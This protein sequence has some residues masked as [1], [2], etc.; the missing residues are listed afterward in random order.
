MIFDP[1][2]VLVLGAGASAP[3]GFPLGHQ[4]K[5]Q[6]IDTTAGD[7]TVS[8]RR[9]QFKEAGFDEKE[10]RE[11]HA[12][13]LR[14]IHPTIDAFLEDRPSRRNIGA[15]AIAQELMSLENQEKFFPHVDWY[16]KLFKELKLHDHGNIANVTAI[17]TF[18]YDRSVEHY[19]RET[20][21]RTYEE[22][23]RDKALE[24]LATVQ[25][26]HVHGQLGQ[27]PEMPY[28]QERTTEDIKKGAQG[29]SMIHDQ[30]LDSSG[31]FQTAARLIADSSDVLFLGCGYDKRTLKRL[32]VA[33]AREGPTFYG[34]THGLEQEWMVEVR[35]MLFEDRISFDGEGSLIDAY[36]DRFYKMKTQQREN[37]ERENKAQQKKLTHTRN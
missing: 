23:A 21:M 19:L 12:D 13:L 3:Y 9:N 34:T 20:A 27:Y 22:V 10:I 16:P 24:K 31:A 26:I 4:L 17:V 8:Q 5:S 18:N 1:G 36:L 32:G 33:G 15:F 30:H 2:T 25:V 35:K 29:I 37:K 7:N 28:V 11:F 14:S 6:I